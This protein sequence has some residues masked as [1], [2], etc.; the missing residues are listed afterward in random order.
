MENLE[1]SNAHGH[2]LKSR[3]SL[4]KE[5]VSTMFLEQVSTYEDMNSSLGVEM[6]I[7]NL[8]LERLR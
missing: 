7:R 8:A 4:G 2:L 5:Q 6:H 3:N 1:T